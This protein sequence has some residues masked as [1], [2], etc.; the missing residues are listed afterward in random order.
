MKS[1]LHLLTL[2]ATVSIPALTQ[3]PAT[4]PP[5]SPPPGNTPAE[6]QK[7]AASASKDNSG[8]S[9][10][11]V[12]KPAG[13][14]GTTLIGCLSGPNADGRYVLTSMQ[15]R[16]GVQVLG[17]DDLKNDSGSKVKLTGAWEA[18]PEQLRQTKAKEARRFQVTA[19][20]VLSPHCTAPS[21]TTP[22]SK[23]KQQ[24][25]QQQQKQREEQQ[26]QK[27]PQ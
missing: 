26:Q 13:A 8:I 9:G 24:E 1:F 2:A 14:K 27:Q 7:N 4:T 18:S 25:R 6:Q 16:T 15:H 11:Q 5:N 22:V 10:D 3:Q 21:T 17:P 19:I 23:A 12:T 20:A